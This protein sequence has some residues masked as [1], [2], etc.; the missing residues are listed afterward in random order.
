MG[1][2]SS[3]AAPKAE[4]DSPSPASRV[5]E[6]EP[7]AEPPRHDEVAEVAQKGE[8]AA[9]PLLSREQESAPGDGDRSTEVPASPERE[10][11]RPA[12]QMSGVSVIDDTADDLGQDPS[13][14]AML[15]ELEGI[16]SSMEAELLDPSRKHNESP[17]R[18][19]LDKDDE[20]LL[21]ELLEDLKDPL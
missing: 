16:M 21:V 9:L 3:A 18:C 8:S 13:H 5:G 6:A 19:E 17:A 15:H 12:S 14:Q 4:V 11:E 20:E 2:G 10:A 7:T 1:C